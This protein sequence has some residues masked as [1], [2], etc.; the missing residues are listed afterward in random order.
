MKP[1]QR[2]SVLIKDIKKKKGY[3]QRAL[4]QKVGVTQSAIRSWENADCLPDTENWQAIAKEAGYSK[5]SDLIA[6]I[7]DESQKEDDT[8]FDSYLNA[9]YQL[10]TRKLAQVVDCSSNL[11]SQAILAE[12]S[13]KYKV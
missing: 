11:L 3:S 13:G 12:D 7:F 6:Y 1:K 8:S 10:D 9:L 5:V 2:L 4:A